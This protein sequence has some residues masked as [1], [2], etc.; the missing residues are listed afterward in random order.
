MFDGAKQDQAQA[1]FASWMSVAHSQK[2]LCHCSTF[3]VQD[4]LFGEVDLYYTEWG[5][6]GSLHTTCHHT[7]DPLAAA[8]LI[9]RT[10]EQKIHEGCVLSLLTIS[11]SC[12]IDLQPAQLKSR[13][14][15]FGSAKLSLISNTLGQTKDFLCRIRGA[16]R[17]VAN[18]HNKTDN[19]CRFVPPAYFSVLA[20]PLRSV[21]ARSDKLLEV[22]FRMEDDG[23]IFLGDL[24]QLTEDHISIYTENK[25]I[26][27]EMV[28]YVKKSDLEMNMVVRRWTRPST[29]GIAMYVNG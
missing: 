27:E 6:D 16:V 26:I 9:Y 1:I 4:T 15:H 10:I 19:V 12:S 11:D 28:S 22:V 25:K 13:Q 20:R 18:M 21:F 14:R 29:F 7:R 8:I 5:Q 17:I 23:I 24:V 2:A 3:R